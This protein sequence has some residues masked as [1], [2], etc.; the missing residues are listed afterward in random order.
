MIYIS[1]RF[2]LALS[3]YVSFI[4]LFFICTSIPLY[5]SQ[6]HLALDQ[7]GTSSK[8]TSLTPS[9]L[10]AN[11]KKYPDDIEN[12]RIEAIK[13]GIQLKLTNNKEEARIFFEKAAILDAPSAMFH[14]GTLESHDN[15]D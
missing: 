13:Q 10:F 1:K 12:K 3:I 9:D 7:R 15:A 2:F 8:K 4:S 6:D 11:T 5:S 14:L